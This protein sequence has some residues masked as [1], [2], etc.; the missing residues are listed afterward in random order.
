MCW[1]LQSSEV[2][3]ITGGLSKHLMEIVVRMNC[4]VQFAV[5]LCSYVGIHVHFATAVMLYR[6]G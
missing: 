3:A 2:L 1:H 5:A 4:G 6:F